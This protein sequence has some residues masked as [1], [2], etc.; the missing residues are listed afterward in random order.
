M[1]NE[2]IKLLENSPLSQFKI[3]SFSILIPITRFHSYPSIINNELSTLDLSTGEEVETKNGYFLY[4]YK[5]IKLRVNKK[6]IPKKGH[7]LNFVITAKML[8]CDYLDG[9]NNFNLSKI[10]NFLYVNNFIFVG[11]SLFT[12]AFIYDFDIC[13][14]FTMSDLSYHHFLLT[15]NK[16]LDI[17][18]S[19]LFYSN[20]G[21]NI[22]K[23]S[24]SG[25]QT[26][27][28]EDASIKLPFIKFYNKSLEL[29]TKSNLFVQ[30]HKLSYSSNIKRFELSIKNS[31]HLQSLTGS[32]RSHFL[33]FFTDKSHI[34]KVLINSLKHLFFNYSNEKIIKVKPNN[35]KRGNETIIFSLIEYIHELE[36]ELFH[37]SA[38]HITT[39]KLLTRIKKKE[40]LN[41]TEISR[42]KKIINKFLD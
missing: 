32:N 21:Q 36:N 14:D 22:I 29:D 20:T 23:K 35:I 30:E 3:D 5:G 15:V 38:P 2:F 39:N 4:D 8:G 13:Y 17:N 10:E 41:T 16:E 24:V 19:R 7:Y 40:I 31:K 11:S 26:L 27:S 33:Y 18:S 1:K 25:Y 12:D 9:I 37:I 6:Y 42:C 34:Q 28:R